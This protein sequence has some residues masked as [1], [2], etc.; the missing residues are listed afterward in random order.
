MRRSMTEQEK[1]HEASVRISWTLPKHINPLTDADI[2]KECMLQ[3]G[4]V[5][6]MNKQYVNETIRRIPIS[7]TTKKI[8]THIWS[9]Q[10]QCDV[11]RQ[12]KSADCY[13]LAM[14]Q[15]CDVT[16]KAQLFL[17]VRYMDKITKKFAKELFSILP[18]L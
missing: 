8:N 2:F 11:K 5:Q 6:F 7:A 15:S 3:A 14:D 4:A 17:L 16:D 13:D 10:N 18:I 9:Q 1:Y 12:F